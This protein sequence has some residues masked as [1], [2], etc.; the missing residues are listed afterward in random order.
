[1][2]APDP[3]PLFPVDRPLFFKAPNNLSSCIYGLIHI[4]TIYRFT[5]FYFCILQSMARESYK[6][7]FNFEIT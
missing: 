3:L 5:H 2:F 6:L 1:M 4:Y 7:L